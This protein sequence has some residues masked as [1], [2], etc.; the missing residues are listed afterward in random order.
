M[1][2]RE[3]RDVEERQVEDRDEE[4]RDVEEMDIVEMKV[5]ESN[6]E[7]RDEEERCAIPS[8]GTE[9]NMAQP[10]NT[11]LRHLSKGLAWKKAWKHS[12]SYPNQ[13]WQKHTQTHGSAH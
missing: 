8:K 5:E 13:T 6:V 3:K 10:D 7:E 9:G 12:Q 4:E 2:K 1:R 11:G